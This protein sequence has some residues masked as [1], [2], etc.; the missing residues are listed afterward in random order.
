M[1]SVIIEDEFAGQEII[2]YKLNK[3]FPDFKIIKTIESKNEAIAYLTTHNLQIDIIFLDIQLKGGTG[4]EVLNA[5]G[6]SRNFEI[7][8]TTA[9]EKYALDAFQLNAI[10]YLLKPVNDVDFKE[11]I[12]RIK[13]KR[14][15]ETETLFIPTRNEHHQVATK[16]ILY[17]KSDGAYTDIFTSQK[18]FT[19]SKN[20]G[21][22]E[23]FLPATQFIRIHHSYIINT[24]KID[25][26]EKGRT[27]FV[28]LQEG[29]KIPVSQRKMPALLSFLKK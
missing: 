21:D 25:H 5:C 29:T 4:I 28:V 9:Y 15:V 22:F 26:I 7:I 20:M 16:D 19:S 23:K 6:E 24:S 13:L 3:Y 2:K 10:H 17:F 8:F 11:A 12:N 27:G 14:N 1:N 18:K